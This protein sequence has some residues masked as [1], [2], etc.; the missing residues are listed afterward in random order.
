[1][2]DGMKPLLP[3]DEGQGLMV[4]AFTSCNLGFGLN[5]SLAQLDEINKK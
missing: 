3:K 2:P 1:M 5:T 4:S